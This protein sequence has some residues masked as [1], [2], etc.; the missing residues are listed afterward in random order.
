MQM[1]NFIDLTAPD[2]FVFP[3]YEARP[4]GPAKT[5]AA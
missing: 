5:A 2:G 4:S 1:A 3:A